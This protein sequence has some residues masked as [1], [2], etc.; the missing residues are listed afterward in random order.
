MSRNDSFNDQM[1]LATRT[2]TKFQ[3]WKPLRAREKSEDGGVSPCRP[4]GSPPPWTKPAT[5]M[6]ALSWPQ[7]SP[8]RH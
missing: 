5:R 2:E 3:P 4:I 6:A 8:D 7:R 1:R